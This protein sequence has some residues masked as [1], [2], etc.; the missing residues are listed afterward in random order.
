MEAQSVPENQPPHLSGATCTVKNHRSV[1]LLAH[2]NGR[3]NT[4][5]NFCEIVL[6]VSIALFE[7]E[8]LK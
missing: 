3:A 2:A 8:V 1:Q 7:K 5:G 4:V 6:S